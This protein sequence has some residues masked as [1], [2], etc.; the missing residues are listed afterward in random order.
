MAPGFA[1]I[2]EQQRPVRILKTLYQK[3]S[4]PHALLFIGQ[5]GVGKQSAAIAFAMTC[6]CIAR[7]A[8]PRS[9]IDA[10]SPPSSPAMS[11][12]EPCGACPACRKIMSATHP[13]VIHIKPTGT[14]LRIAQVREL[15]ETLSLKPY[16]AKM[17]FVII[18]DA[19]AMNPAAGN[20]L[21]KMLEEPPARTILILTAPQSAD[22][23]P[24]IV[25]RCQ[26]V[27]FN[28]I[29]RRVLAAWLVETCGLEPTA[30]S[31]LAA[32]ASG[33]LT[34][35]QSLAQSDW[36]RYR[37][38]LIDRSGLMAPENL[39]ARDIGQLLAF[40]ETLATRKE[41]VADALA[42]LLTW[43]RD[44]IVCRYDPERVVN[45]DMGENLQTASQRNP[46]SA[47]LDKME[48]IR[49]AQKNIEANAN[50]R[51]ALEVMML[52]LAAA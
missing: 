37:S 7:P 29:S 31:V 1:S 38:W 10:G 42:A 20:A 21:L 5:E 26:P 39:A 27:R 13:D 23:L 36:L 40:A 49:T 35:A 50:L 33:S 3:K 28:P 51:L 2:L 4:I 25:S 52:R 34:R 47:V 32:V 43:L 6:N 9:P 41:S 18:R 14:T 16:E 44:L 30:A 24:T 15:R 12:A 48:A 22:L 19:H 46:V 45:A 11:A 8:P 17:R